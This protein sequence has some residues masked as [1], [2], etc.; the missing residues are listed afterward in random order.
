MTLPKA[1][2]K[3]GKIRPFLMSRQRL[4]NDF[5]RV[6]V[7]DMVNSETDA[8]DLHNRICTLE[9]I[10]ALS[11]ELDIIGSTFSDNSYYIIEKL[12]LARQ[13]Y[14]ATASLSNMVK[15]LNNLI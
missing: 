5:V 9:A 7:L 2:M 6:E 10:I 8:T 3:S 14:Y 13:I 1:F 4:T 12:F 11:Y 15:T